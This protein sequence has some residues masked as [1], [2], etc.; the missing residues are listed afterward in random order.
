MAPSPLP[1]FCR[2][3]EQHMHDDERA[4]RDLVAAWMARETFR[5]TMVVIHDYEAVLISS[6][7]LIA[8]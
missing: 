1:M 7:I 8:R 2:R 6:C 4:I 5:Q 3:K